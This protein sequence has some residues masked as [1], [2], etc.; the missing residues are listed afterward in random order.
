MIEVEYLQKV[1]GKIT[2]DIKFSFT[3]D[4]Y[5]GE[6]TFDGVTKKER[7]NYYMGA[8]ALQYKFR[9]WLQLDLGYVFDKRD[10]NFSDFDYTVNIAFVRIT[11]SL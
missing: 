2:A 6:T 5:D 7:D 11:G 9:E 4:Q 10:S 8:F 3:N 1:T